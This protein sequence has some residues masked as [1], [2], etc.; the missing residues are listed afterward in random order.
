MRERQSKRARER[1]FERVREKERR[2]ERKTERV[3][4]ETEVRAA[5]HEAMEGEGGWPTTQ[6]FVLQKRDSV[7]KNLDSAHFGDEM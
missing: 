1:E 2:A 7:T 3:Q 4:V 6:V 5:A